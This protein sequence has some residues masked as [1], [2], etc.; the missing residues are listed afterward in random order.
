MITNPVS[1]AIGPIQLDLCCEDP[2]THAWLVSYYA[3]FLRDGGTGYP[4]HISFEKRSDNRPLSGSEIS[5]LPSVVS[6]NSPGYSGEIRFDRGAHLR[7]AT[8]HAE[9][10]ID[11]FLRVVTAIL[12]FETGGLLFHAA[13][14]LHGE[15]G[16]VFFGHSGSGKTTVARLST[17]DVVLNDD[18]LILSPVERGWRVHSTPFWNPTQ[19]QPNNQSAMVHSMYRL[20]KDQ[21][22]YLEDMSF[23]QAVGELIA[24]T[25]VLTTDEKRLP[26][27]LDRC[28][29]ISQQIPV[30]WLHFLKDDTFWLVIDR[31]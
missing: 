14:I 10:G 18:L 27:V 31:P 6:I 8:D 7:I 28:V 16:Y 12:A 17:N 2:A 15:K 22:V 1:L 26:E 29:R 13:G 19:N 9:P 3:A 5:F 30:R 24:S 11:Y 23:A 21:S 4:V 25:P 20:V